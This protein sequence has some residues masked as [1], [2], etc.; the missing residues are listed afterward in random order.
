MQLSEILKGV[1]TLGRKGKQDGDVLSVCYDSGRCSPGSLFT[2]IA[3]LK[4]D[5]HLYIEN[6]LQQGAL[7]VVHER[8]FNPP[9]GVTAIRVRDSRRALGQIGRNFFR[10]PSSS[11]CLIAVT[12]TNGKTTTTY[13]LES[14]L[15]NA[16]HK[17]GVIGT[18][19]YRYGQT[20]VPAPNTTPESFEMQRILR[21]MVD[22]GVTHC[23]AEVSSHALD[24]RRV[25]DCAFDMGIF[26]NLT[27]D[28]LDYHD[29]MENYFHAKKRFFSE[30]LPSSSKTGSRIMAINGD[31][32]W[33]QRI[34]RETS[35]KHVTY[36]IAEA[37]DVTPRWFKLSLDG[38]SAK[39]VSKTSELDIEAPLLGKFNLYNILAAVAASLAI[40]V[41]ADV[42]QRGLAL[43]PQVPGR[44]EKVS[45]PGQ[46][47]VFV[48]Y[49]HTDDALT[50]VLENLS[51][52]R[53]GRLITVFGCGGDRDRGK[54]PLM[55]QAATRY[56]DLTIVTSDNPRSEAPLK[57]IDDI[58]SGIRITRIELPKGAASPASA[59]PVNDSEKRYA[60]IPDRGEAIMTAVASAQKEDIVLIAGK[61]HEDYQI[62]GGTKFSFD[63]RQVAREAL[64]N[65]HRK[66]ESA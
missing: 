24:L 61:G 37:C 6:A 46:P 58:E 19:N 16:G 41:P 22:N 30:L 1:E 40:G 26:T 51:S 31:D 23:I 60:V 12:G 39:I 59:L 10:D 55:G 28:H 62:I 14:I 27:Q 8:D 66:G 52:L 7:F 5:G 54:R 25:D 48:D 3:G 13:L 29:N 65:Y 35:G 34:I 11:L 2:A 47:S 43:M 33:G 38:I 45:L 50:R 42:I 53:R 17:V 9:P 44:L 64:E 18:V 63:D 49:A 56:S 15:A 32:A 57:I 21:E 20:V 4:T 36:G